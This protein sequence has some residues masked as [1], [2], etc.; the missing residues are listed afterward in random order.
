METAKTYT[1][2]F[3]GSTMTVDV[4]QEFIEKLVAHFGLASVDD[5]SNEHIHMFMFNVTKTAYDKL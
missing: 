3:N 5:V 2:P 4:T 1:L